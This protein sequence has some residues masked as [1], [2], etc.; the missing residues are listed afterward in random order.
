MK[1]P[2]K[3]LSIVPATTAIGHLPPTQPPPRKADIIVALVERAR[4]KHEEEVAANN[5]VLQ[6]AKAKVDQA[7]LAELE[8]S[9]KA[10]KTSVSTW[11]AGFRVEYV[12]TVT[13]P[14]IEKLIKAER[15]IPR[16]RSFDAYAVKREITARLSGGITGD[17]VKALLASPDAV[18]KL[19]ATLQA[20]FS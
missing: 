3:K 6:E 17:R 4:V 5:K 20:I 7:C 9:P 1:R 12:A 8:K 18:K 2:N 15:A 16:L 11:S 10:F 14:H 19:D 13:P